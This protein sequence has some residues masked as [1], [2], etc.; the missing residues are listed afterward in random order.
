MPT[1]RDENLIFCD[2][3]L[4]GGAIEIS[5][6][7]LE[8]MVKATAA[9][10]F[11]GVS[12]WAFHHLAVVG[13]GR[14]D[15]E[16][17]ALHTD[18]GLAVPVVESLIGWEGGD[19]AAIDAQCG[20]T[21]DVAARYGAKT[22]AGVVMSPA[23]ESFDAA[24][25]GLA[26]LGKSA[27]DRGMRVC[28]EWLPWSGLPDLKSAWRMVQATGLDNVGLV[29]DTWHWLR[30]PGGPDLE[31]LR[32]VPGERVHLVQ[33]DDAAREP[34]GDDAMMESMTK[35]ELPGDGDVDFAELFGVLD[36][37]GADPIW[38]PE[39]FNPGLMALGHEEMAKRIYASTRKILGMA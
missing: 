6:A 36:E 10:G 14:S 25:A 22:V 34:S 21:F 3:G 31:T 33:L 17:L 12:L 20:P 37:I 2:A 7:D 18:A 35:R 30:Q 8:S 23:L 32:Q 28:I 26:H 5:P 15:E 38:A 27:S 19:T 29:V 11:K 9:A 1:V 16:L 39:I 4:V 13:A 24:T